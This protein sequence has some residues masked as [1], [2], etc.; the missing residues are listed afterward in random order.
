MCVTNGND[1][2]IF[3]QGSMNKN[4]SRI[5]VVLPICFYVQSLLF[6]VMIQYIYHYNYFTFSTIVALNSVK[7]RKC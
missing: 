5:I 6:Q 1:F 4:R 2:T 3:N 7:K